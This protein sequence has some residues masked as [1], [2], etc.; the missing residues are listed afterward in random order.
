[1]SPAL[2]RQ[3][4]FGLEGYRRIRAVDILLDDDVPPGNLREGTL[5]QIL[6]PGLEARV[7]NAGCAWVRFYNLFLLPLWPLAVL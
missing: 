5:G 2:N 3:I 7:S 6:I 1:M 4:T